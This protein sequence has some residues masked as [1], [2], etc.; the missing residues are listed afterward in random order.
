MFSKT[1]EKK[2]LRQKSAFG[3]LISRKLKHNDKYKKESNWPL[4]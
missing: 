2:K 1:K 4:T 3:R